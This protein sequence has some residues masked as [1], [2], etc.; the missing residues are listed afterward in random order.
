MSSKEKLRIQVIKSF[1]GA[2]GGLGSLGRSLGKVSGSFGLQSGGFLG[3]SG[4]WSRPPKGRALGDLEL[5]NS[6][7]A[8]VVLGPNTRDH[9]VWWL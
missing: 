1:D 4:V 7:L 9:G 2:N 6:M 8:S 5:L 3:G